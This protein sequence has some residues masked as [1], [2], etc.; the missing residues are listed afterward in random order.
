[1]GGKTKERRKA[2]SHQSVWTN[3]SVLQL[4]RERILNPK[5]T[6]DKEPRRER[7]QGTEWEAGVCKVS[8]RVWGWDGEGGVPEWGLVGFQDLRLGQAQGLVVFLS[9]GIDL[10]FFTRREAL[11]H[12]TAVLHINTK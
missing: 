9:P 2:T 8:W 10:R 12:S 7:Q 5:V 3:V 6:R 1:M 11:Q 4:R